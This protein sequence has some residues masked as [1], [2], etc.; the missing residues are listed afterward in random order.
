MK[1][2][3]EFSIK[4]ERVRQMLEELDLYGC[5]L[6]R[7]DN[8]S[9][10]T[11]GGINY[12]AIGEMGNCGLLIT[13][14]RLYAI[15]N[16]IE[17]PRMRVEEKLEEFGFQILDSIWHKAGYE[18]DLIASVCQEQ[19]VGYDHKNQGPDISSNL[20]RL[21]F[22]LTQEE[23]ERYLEGG[24]K[25]SRLIEEAAASIR[26]GDTEWSVT[27]KVMNLAREDG[28]EAL[29]V[30]CGSDERIVDYRHAIATDKKIRERVQMGGN[31]RYKGLVMCCT[32]YVNFVPVTEELHKQY[33]DN[34]RIDC[35]M[36]GKSIPGNSFQVPFLAGK[37]AYEEL[38]YTGEF[39]KHHQGGP[40]GYLPRDYRIDFSHEGIIAENQAF[41]WNPSITGTKSE[42]TII[43]TKEGPVFVTRPYLFPKL[44]IEVDGRQYIRPDILEKY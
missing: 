22:S 24:R 39:D 30:F 8:F 12:V 35:R 26:P 2:S 42:D 31:L 17:A 27:A 41:C 33:L 6:K 3:H 19:L 7:Q 28:L 40:I 32:R 14:E 43:A 15:T 4:L 16:N 36:I 21:R 11:C 23:V 13:R 18:G 44:Q 34:V 38:G 10:L 9:W 5:Y 25:M 37:D 20:Q 1:Q 29:S